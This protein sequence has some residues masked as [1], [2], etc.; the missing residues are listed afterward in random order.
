MDVVL[1]PIESATDTWSL[2]DRLGR[3]L[4]T[5][6]KIADA[7]G[8]K[9]Q[10]QLGSSLDGVVTTHPTLDAVMTAVGKRMDG[11]CTLDSQD[12]D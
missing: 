5:V 3:S 10:A 6:S 12:W 9:I 8:F 4:G 1:T 2:K 7:D 11:A